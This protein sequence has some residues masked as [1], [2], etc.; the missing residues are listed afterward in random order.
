MLLESIEK[1]RLRNVL[2]AIL[3]VVL[4]GG[5]FL[6]KIGGL[7]LP[8]TLLVISLWLAIYSSKLLV[9]G[10][11]AGIVL[12]ATFLCVSPILS[13]CFV[14]TTD[15]DQMTEAL[16]AFFE[17]ELRGIFVGAASTANALANRG[18]VEQSRDIKVIIATASPSWVIF[19]MWLL[20]AVLSSSGKVLDLPRVG[21]RIY[22][23]K[24]AKLACILLIALLFMPVLMMN[25][26]TENCS[27]RRCGLEQG[28]IFIYMF[29][30]CFSA[31][32]T[33]CIVSS[34]AW[35][36]VSSCVLKSRNLRE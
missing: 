3:G 21:E 23:L 8:V 24:Q 18:M 30:Y 26:Y 35:L 20:V 13:I 31:V 17:K 25:F 7:V 28:S 12:P 15:H 5:F 1:A 10:S 22:V 6:L 27:G 11:V 14:L 33:I 32:S 16:S 36:S 4:G 19:G 29:W 2:M 9:F 34:F